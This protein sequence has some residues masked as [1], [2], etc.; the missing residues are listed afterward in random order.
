MAQKVFVIG[1]TGYLGYHLC[2]ELVAKGYLVTALS[3]DDV[4]PGFLPPEVTVVKANIN[5]LS[6]KELNDLFHGHWGFIF[7]AGADDRITPKAPAYPFFFNANV[8]SLDRL[9]T[10]AKIQQVQR[11]VILNSYFA[12]FNRLWPEMKLAKTHPYI[13]SRK[14]QQEMAF[15]VSGTTMPTAIVELPYIVGVTPGKGSLWQPLVDYVNSP[16]S[17]KFYTAG[18]TAV[19]SVRN[20]G[21]ALANALEKTTVN[22]IYQVADINLSWANWLQHL[23]KDPNKKLKVITI[24]K[25][26][27]KLAGFFINLLHKFQGKEGGLNIV[28]FVDLQTKETFIPIEEV[29]ARLNYLKYDIAE[30]FKATVDLCTNK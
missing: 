25:I 24:P 4:P 18:G 7:A 30:D 27:I 3:F 16:G 2:R 22:S 1:G 13:R 12:Y 6:D 29:N 9:M 8:K 15:R 28:P 20:V 19:T 5:D 23:V 14:E 11:V 17:L 10:I 26:F 21:L